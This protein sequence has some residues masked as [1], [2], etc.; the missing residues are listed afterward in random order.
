[1]STY[2]YRSLIDLSVEVVYTNKDKQ[3]QSINV[4]GLND[5]RVK[6]DSSYCYEDL[7]LLAVE[8]FLPGWVL[9]LQFNKTTTEY[10]LSFVD[11][12]FNFNG[13]NFNAL[14]DT[15]QHY[16]QNYNLKELGA[17]LGCEHQSSSLQLDMNVVNETAPPVTSVRL[18]FN[19]PKVLAFA[20]SG[21]DC[22]LATRND[23]T[24]PLVVGISLCVLIVVVIVVFLFGRRHYRKL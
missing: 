22:Q 12:G 7:Q 6:N 13:S 3:V 19:Q 23:Y 18:I 5:G 1:M 15:T 10:F 21:I 8:D 11:L 17:H 2:R 4:T 14:D 9:R 20:N 24:V 16:A